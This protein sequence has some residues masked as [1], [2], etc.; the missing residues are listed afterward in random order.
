[1]TDYT[2]VIR[3]VDSLGR[4]A[5]RQV[6]I[7]VADYDP[8]A[9]YVVSLAHFDEDLTDECGLTWVKGGSL[10]PF[11]DDSQVRFG[12][13]SLRVGNTPGWIEAE[14]P[15]LVWGTGDWCWEANVRFTSIVDNR[16]IFSLPGNW[17]LYLGGNG[18]VYV[19]NGSINVISAGTV[20]LNIWLHFALVRSGNQLRLWINGVSRGTYTLPGTNFTQNKMRIGSSTLGAGPLNGWIDEVRLT[21]G[22]PRY[23]AS[24]PVPARPFKI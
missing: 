2:P 15:S 4:V 7:R 10:H 1:M 22:H 5:T 3:A 12:A 24:F 8:L 6:L 23:T 14:S 19:Y 16:G 21:R 13:G 20:G 17:S 11:V 9:E 18:T